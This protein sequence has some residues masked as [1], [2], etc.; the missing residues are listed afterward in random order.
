MVYIVLPIGSCIFILFIDLISTRERRPS[1]TRGAVLLNTYADVQITKKAGE[2]QYFEQL[3]KYD[4]IRN[5]AYHLRHPF[6]SFI[7]NVTHTLYITVPIALLYVT[8]VL[9]NV[10]HYADPELFIDCRGRPHRHR[11]SDRAYPLRNFL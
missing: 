10:P 5:L 3:K 4:R 2:E 11:P 7:S 1:I 9:L 8:A 6:E